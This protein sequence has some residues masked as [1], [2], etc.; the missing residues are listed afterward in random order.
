MAGVEDIEHGDGGT[1]EV[2]ALMKEHNVAFCPTLA[3]GDATSQ[4]A[5]WKKGADPEPRRGIAQRAVRKIAIQGAAGSCARVRRN[6]LSPP[7]LVSSQVNGSI[8]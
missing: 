8:G 7:A 3:A 2:F 5:G 1:P 6:T 4:Y